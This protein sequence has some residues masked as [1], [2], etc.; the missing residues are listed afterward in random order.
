MLICDCYYA[1]IHT[2]QYK[3]LQYLPIGM[4]VQSSDALL[5]C[6]AGHY[7]A[8]IAYIALI[9]LAYLDT[10]TGTYMHPSIH[11]CTHTHRHNIC[12]IMI[13]NLYNSNLVLLVLQSSPNQFPNLTFRN[14]LVESSMCVSRNL[15]YL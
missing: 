4:K 14:N 11:Q 7:I 8:N 10:H 2:S 5:L 13:S 3:K 6:S 15:R 9:E 1:C 12:I